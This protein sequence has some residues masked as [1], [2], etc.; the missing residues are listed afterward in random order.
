MSESVQETHLYFTTNPRSI[1]E[2]EDV[3]SKSVFSSIMRPATFF[4]RQRE[5]PASLLFKRAFA[6]KAQW[7]VSI[8]LTLGALQRWASSIPYIRAPFK[9][10]NFLTAGTGG[11]WTLLSILAFLGPGKVDQKTSSLVIRDPNLYRKLAAATATGFTPTPLATLSVPQVFS[12][13]CTLVQGDWIYCKIG[14]R[15][16][17][18]AHISSR[19]TKREN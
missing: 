18:L 13:I 2:F 9:V 11:F 8:T 15:S 12:V 7:L 19:A 10:Y 6:G 17:C 14:S 1:V 5:K 4:L 16:A 3:C